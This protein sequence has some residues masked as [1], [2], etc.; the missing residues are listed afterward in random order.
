M[1]CD[2]DRAGELAWLAGRSYRF[3][4]IGMPGLAFNVKYARGEGYGDDPDRDEFDITLAYRPPN[5]VFPSW[6]VLRGFWARRRYATL[7]EFDQRRLDDLR[8]II[9]YEVPLL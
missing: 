4:R 8:M 1:I 5:T 9:N 7:D 2:F 6:T 3:D